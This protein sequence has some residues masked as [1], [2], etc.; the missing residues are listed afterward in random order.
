MQVRFAMVLVALALVMLFAQ[1]ALAAEETHEGIVVKA[2]Q[3]KLTMTDKDGKNQHTHNV[4]LE[5][6]IT[7][8]GKPC[9]LEDLKE[10]FSV[11]VTTKDDRTVA[12]IEAKS[13]K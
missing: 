4:P 2:G 13:K 8:D 9:R 6:K 10:G 11:K 5:A 3:G 7:C 1:P 12:T